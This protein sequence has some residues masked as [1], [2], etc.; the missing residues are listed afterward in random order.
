MH[1]EEEEEMDEEQAAV[2]NPIHYSAPVPATPTQ[3]SPA[4][5]ITYANRN[6]WFGQR[7][8]AGTVLGEGL[9]H[10]VGGRASFGRAAHG[11]QTTATSCPPTSQCTTVCHNTIFSD[12]LWLASQ[13]TRWWRGVG[14]QLVWVMV[15]GIIPRS[16]AGPGGAAAVMCVLC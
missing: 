15:G 6:V 3:R 12:V 13:T 7:S 1:E 2:R 16:S 14:L 5:I 10:E 9:M 11:I 4:Q 8:Q